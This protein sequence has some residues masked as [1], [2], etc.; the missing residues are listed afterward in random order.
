MARKIS[1]M[2]RQKMARIIETYNETTRGKINL[3][4]GL[5]WRAKFLFSRAKKFWI[6]A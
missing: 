5:Q 1:T 2:P 4:F 6:G 3:L